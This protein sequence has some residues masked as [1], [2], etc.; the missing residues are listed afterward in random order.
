MRINFEI[1]WKKTYVVFIMALFL[2]ISIFW[3]SYINES[4]GVTLYLINKAISLSPLNL[5]FQ[6]I[7]ITIIDILIITLP[8]LVLFLLPQTKKG[9]A[10]EELIKEFEK[11]WEIKKAELKLKKLKGGKNGRRKS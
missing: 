7:L 9:K 8:F 4:V 6:L 5:F 1:N 11:N 2:W 3:Y 10:K